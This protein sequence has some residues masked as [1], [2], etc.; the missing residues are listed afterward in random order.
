MSEDWDFVKAKIDYMSHGFHIY[1]AR[2]IP[3]IAEK[4]ISKFYRPN[5]EGKLILDPFCGSGGVLVEALLKNID[6]V[7]IDL[8]P[9]ATLLAKVKT[10]PLEP[11]KLHATFTKIWNEIKNEAFLKRDWIKVE[12][13]LVNANKSKN[14]DEKVRIL[15]KVQEKCKSLDV[16]IPDIFNTN[17]FY[18][19]KPHVIRDLIIIKKHISQIHNK[20]EKDFFNVCFSATIR[21]VSGARKGE[22]KLY[23]ISKAEWKKFN[24]PTFKIFRNKVIENISK[25]GEFY[26][27]VKNNKSRAYIFEFDTKKLF[28]A[29]CPAKIAN[30]LKENS[31]NLIVTS[32]PY[33]D[34]HTTVAY[35]QFSRYSLLWLGYP[36][37]NIWKID[38]ESLGGVV[39][40]NEI[41]SKS[42]KEI[43]EKIENKLRAREVR[44]FFIDL[45]TCLEKLSRLLTIKGYACFVLGNRTVSGQKILTDKI[46]TELSNPLRLKH[47]VTYYRN[48]P[49]KR[50][51]WKGSPSNISG[52]KVETISKERI[53][54]LQKI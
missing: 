5:L 53:I 10:T 44:S 34:S 27:A 8:N 4:L 29:E 46:I 51:P 3:Q 1:P 38:D 41:E 37:E 6:A 52:Q 42:L 36:K 23:R 26:E 43:L 14:D 18:W 28:S 40:E 2:M 12:K 45:N 50:I 33:G 20:D 25:M 22:F 30:I 21:A 19:F 9:L 31:V 11:N 39:K 7:G 35:G 15:E 17:L 49:S 54:I 24:P 16:E 47:I 32:P 48:I 13:L